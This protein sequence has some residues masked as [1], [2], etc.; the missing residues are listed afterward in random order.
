[1]VVLY[2]DKFDFIVVI[3]IVVYVGFNWEKLGCIGFVY[4][5]EYMLFNDLENVFKGVNCKMIFELGG[6]C[7]GG[8]WSDG[9]IYYEV[10]LKDVFDKLLWIDFDC[11]GY[12]INIVDQGILEC[13]KQVVKNEKC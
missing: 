12:M 8:I 13:E 2:V 11:L 10:V 1:M 9:M 6:I 3:V 4:F 5:F 7:N